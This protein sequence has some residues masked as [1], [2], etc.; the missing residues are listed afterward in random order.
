MLAFSCDHCGLPILQHWRQAARAN[1]HFCGRACASAARRV[2]V[3]VNCA[4][5]N[6]D[7]ETIPFYVGKIVTCSRKCLKER[8]R[9]L[10]IEQASKVDESPIY[11]FGKYHHTPRK[12]CEADIKAIRSDS[13]NQSTIAKDYGISQQMISQIKTRRTWANIDNV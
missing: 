4:I 13:R 10:L 1:K 6:N 3:K 12:L 11:N 9:I 8:R 2:R 7:F 5:C